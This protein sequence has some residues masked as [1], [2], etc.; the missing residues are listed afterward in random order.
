MVRG[1][2]EIM[3]AGF[4]VETEGLGGRLLSVQWGMMGTVYYECGPDMLQKF[5][6]SMLEYSEPFIWYGHFAQY[7][8]RYMVDAL[9]DMGHL[10]EVGMRTETDIYEIRIVRIIDGKKVKTIMRDS[11]AIWSHPLAELAKQFCPEMPKLDL[12]FDNVTFDPHNPEHI[13]YAKRDIMVLLVGLPR[14]FQ[15][16]YD[17]FGVNPNATAASTALKAWQKS[18]SKDAIYNASKYGAQEV[19]IRQAYYGGLVFL[20]DT[21]THKDAITVDRNSS[22]PYSMCEY[23]V[24]YGR[25]METTDYQSGLMGIYRCRVRAPENLRIPIIPARDKKGGMR[26]YRGE[27]DTVCTNVEL[28]FAANH[29]YEI[30][31]IYEGMAWEGVVFP[32]NDF[33]S[34]CKLIRKTYP[35]QS[36]EFVAKL[37]Q[38]SLYG[39]FGSRRER[40]QIISALSMVDDDLLGAVPLDEHGRW[41]VKKELDEEMRCLPEW[42]VFITAHSRLGLLKEAYTAGPENV[43]Y[44]DTD[45]LTIINGAHTN[46]DIGGEYGQWKVEKEW[47]EFRAIAPKVYTG[48]LQKA[49]KK[50]RTRTG[51]AKGLPR[52]GITDLHWQQL[53]EDGTTSA[54]ALSL[55]SLRVAMAKGNTPAVQLLRKSST[56]ENSSNF[57]KLQD[58]SVRLK[59]A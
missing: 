7:D 33:I 26:W 22:Y 51:A 27:F 3:V 9:F 13:E 41:Y 23:G 28:I 16:I 24:P 15:M 54:Q 37:M 52:K 36:M 14:L 11:Y 57:E 17:L 46:I 38:N 12:D 42:A 53:L 59:I 30:L 20:T 10:I 21:N 32:F 25:V 8:W 45:S 19:F 35:G 1:D 56:L 48:I 2:D 34:L 31:E 49:D 44:G 47:K 55:P 18:L 4:D 50:G 39:K 29:G 40:R 43:L 58:G 5:L 6:A